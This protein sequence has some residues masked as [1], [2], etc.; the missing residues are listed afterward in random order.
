[1]DPYLGLVDCVQ[2]IVR[3]EGWTALYRGWWLTLVFGVF[4]AFA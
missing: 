4:G 1:M 2:K 3:E